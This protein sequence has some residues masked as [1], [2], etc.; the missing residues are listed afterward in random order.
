MDKLANFAHSIRLKSLLAKPSSYGI[1]KGNL[2]EVI[3]SCN[4][5]AMT[6]LAACGDVNRNVMCNPNP[7]ASEITLKCNA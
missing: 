6:T 3:S 1:L 4:E 7:F 2:K 5:V